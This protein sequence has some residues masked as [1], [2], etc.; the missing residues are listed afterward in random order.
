M[1]M[2]PSYG[3]KN[4]V[5][6][7]ELWLRNFMYAL[8]KLWALEVYYRG[9]KRSLKIPILIHISSCLYPVFSLIFSSHQCLGFPSGLLPTDT[10]FAPSHSTYVPQALPI[11]MFLIWSPE[12][13]LKLKILMQFLPFTSHL[14]QNVFLSTLSSN[15]PILCFSIHVLL[16]Q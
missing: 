15:T 6:D 8:Y 16:S 9:H 12:Y 1:Q 11:T 4:I 7:T 5:L 2:L 10:S 14:V 13:L 3:R